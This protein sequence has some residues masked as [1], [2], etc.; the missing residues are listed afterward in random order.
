MSLECLDLCQYFHT[1]D[2]GKKDE[3]YWQIRRKM[4]KRRLSAKLPNIPKEAK[5]NP[6]PIFCKEGSPYK[7]LTIDPEIGPKCEKIVSYW[8][9]SES[10]V[11][12]INKSFNLGNFLRASRSTVSR[13]SLNLSLSWIS[14][15][16]TCVTELKASNPPIRVR[17][18]TPLVQNVS[19]VLGLVLLSNRIW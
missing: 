2:I 4:L 10:T 12:D 7:G 19:N 17:S 5:L 1:V 6:R 14:S 9:S 13:K 18:K 11:A 8:K 3:T 15:T 16:M